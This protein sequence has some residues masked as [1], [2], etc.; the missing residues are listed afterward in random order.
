MPMMNQKVSDV[1]QSK[2][3][4]LRTGALIGPSEAEDGSP[5]TRRKINIF[6]LC[7]FVLFRCLMS[8]IMAA[9]FFNQSTDQALLSSRNA[10]RNI[11]RNKPDL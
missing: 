11:P 7:L 3:K 8:R 10:L 2:F 9:H 6:F 5:R 4:G 1:I